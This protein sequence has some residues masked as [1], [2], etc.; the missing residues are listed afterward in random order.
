VL[1]KKPKILIIDDEKNFCYFV[2]RNLEI[3]GNYKVIIARSGK[4]GIL[5]TYIYRPDLI[6]LDIMMPGISGFE[7]LRRI[8]EGKKTLAIPVIMLTARNDDESKIKATNYYYEDYIVKPIEIGILRSK[9]DKALK[10]FKRNKRLRYKKE[11][12]FYP[13]Y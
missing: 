1:V 7:V 4:K 5:F 13:F 6:L 11:R 10:R 8:K 2:K 12:F 9:I 3:L